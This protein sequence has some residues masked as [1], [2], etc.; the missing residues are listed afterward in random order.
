MT[1]RAR[2]RFGQNFLCDD[3]IVHSI[4]ALVSPQEQ[5]Y[6]LEIGPGQGVLT[7]HLLKSCHHL[8]V[9]EIDRDL[10][11][12]LQKEFALHTG[13]TIHQADALKFDFKS[14]CAAAG[15]HKLRVIGNLPYNISTPLIFHMLDFLPYIEDMHFMLQK[16]V[17]DRIAASPGNKQYGRLSVMV[18]ARCEV[19]VLLEV[20]PSAF[21]PAPKVD[22][23]VFRLQPRYYPGVEQQLLP[24]LEKVVGLAF[25]HRR[26][27]VR[28]NLKSLVI[29]EYLEAAGV[30][31]TARPEELS[32][33][34][35]I[36]ISRLL[37]DN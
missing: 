31:A 33:E 16:E 28:N 4:I 29:P 34:Q 32:L 3:G 37:M 10:V 30:M 17:V 19:E 5:D 1:H 12:A 6:F 23:A 25:S 20:P 27:L 15:K 18:Q 22:S 8:D 21:R 14:L 7:R 9:I 36:K 35:Y 2:K 26:K 11:A 13:L 24:W